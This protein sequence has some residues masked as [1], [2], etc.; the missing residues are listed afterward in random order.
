MYEIDSITKQIILDEY[1]S[2]IEKAKKI[3]TSK[4][5]IIIDFYLEEAK[6]KLLKNTNNKFLIK[7]LTKNF[8]CTPFSKNK[9]VDIQPALFTWFFTQ[10]QILLPFRKIFDKP[11]KQL[12]CTMYYFQG[13]QIYLNYLID[14]FETPEDIINFFDK[15]KEEDSEKVMTNYLAF[16]YTSTM[17]CVAKKFYKN[18]F[19]L[20]WLT[21][22]KDFS[23]VHKCLNYLGRRYAY[24]SLRYY[25]KSKNIKIFNNPNDNIIIYGIA[26]NSKMGKEGKITENVLKTIKSNHKNHMKNLYNKRYKIIEEDM[27]GI[28]PDFKNKKLSY[29]EK[30]YC[31]NREFSFADFFIKVDYINE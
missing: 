3:C 12:Y 29:F 7:E 14:L 10:T 22:I 18:N 21:F 5:S 2:F 25:D 8:I 27:I 6:E 9:Y 23:D 17:F 16:C 20:S 15:C 1:K 19:Y 28:V 26:I 11:F 4:E 13:Y 30:L 24:I 31:V